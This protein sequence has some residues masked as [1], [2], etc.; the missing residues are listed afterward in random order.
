MSKRG[1]GV[2]AGGYNRDMDI[3]KVHPKEDLLLVE[4]QGPYYVEQANDVGIIVPVVGEED[5]QSLEVG[6]IRRVGPGLLERGGSRRPLDVSVGDRIL[7]DRYAGKADFWGLRAG[8]PDFVIMSAD[9]P[10]AIL[11]A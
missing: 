2:R 11:G 9:E 10:I 3:E 8:E 6:V 7:F 1:C 4:R 5:K